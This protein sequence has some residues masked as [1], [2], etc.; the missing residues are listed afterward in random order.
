M[1]IERITKQQ[2][3]GLV[4]SVMEAIK[5]ANAGAHP[6]DAIIKVATIKKYAK[7]YVQ[8]MVEAFN[9]SKGIKH[10]K[11]ASGDAKAAS[12]DIADPDVIFKAMY[13]DNVAAPAE[14]KA[15]EWEPSG[16]NMDETRVFDLDSAP[17]VSE[18]AEEVHSYGQPSVDLLMKQACNEMYRQEREVA[19]ARGEMAA[20]RERL[21]DGIIKLSSYFKT[22]TH[23]PFEQFEKIAL[24]FGGKSLEPVLSEIWSAA[25]L[26]RNP[27]DK[28]ASGAAAAAP[29]DRTP[30]AILD[31]IIDAR[32]LYGSLAVKAAKLQAKLAVYRAGL[33]ERMQALI[34]V[35][36]VVTP[37]MLGALLPKGLNESFAKGMATPG[38][39]TLEDITSIDFDAER[40]GIQAK[41]MLHD[42]LKYDDV[43]R[44]ADPN[45]VVQ[46]FNDI[47]KVAP[48]AV[49]SPLIMRGLMRK[50]IESNTYDP[51]EITNLINIETG[52]KKRDAPVKVDQGA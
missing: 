18:K 7:P 47:S 39:K 26:E 30:Y 51:F 45:K 8:R 38:S 4:D 36:D 19:T 20:V 22:S 14:V 32:N 5:L 24:Q 28:R 3:A 2:E 52:L 31:D 6:N 21:R 35:A 29:E 13:P 37:F 27:R 12:F 17:V 10:R 50:A 48:R 42:M 15:A 41:T 44:R 25:R 16:T 33:H 49:D 1:T 11:E 9:V 46:V 34:K 43:L 40:K 23:E